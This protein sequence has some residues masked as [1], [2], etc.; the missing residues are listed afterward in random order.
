MEF[1][2]NWIGKRGNVK[3]Q[4][5]EIDRIRVHQILEHLTPKTIDSRNPLSLLIILNFMTFLSLYTI[6]FSSSPAVVCCFSQR[7]TEKIYFTCC[8][9]LI[10]FPFGKYEKLTW[11]KWKE[12]SFS[13][14][15]SK[16]QGQMTRETRAEPEN[17]TTVR[18]TLIQII[19][20][21]M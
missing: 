21:R 2:M 13:L 3:S 16:A 7:Q 19:R 6:H 8:Y 15:S 11:K 4:E 10:E 14:S 12:K 20:H 17:E 9:L 1:Q 18:E 5:F